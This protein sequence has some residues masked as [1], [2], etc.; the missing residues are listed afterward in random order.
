M[1]KIDVAGFYCPS[2]R[3]GVR[4]EDLP[5]MFENWEAGG[6]DYGGCVGESNYWYDNGHQSEPA[7]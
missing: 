3:N 5:I 7:V 2:R 1:A 4:S 6:T